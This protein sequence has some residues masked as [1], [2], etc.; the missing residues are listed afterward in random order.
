MLVARDGHRRVA[1]AQAAAVITTI[2]EVH[3]KFANL[4]DARRTLD[5]DME[6]IA[7]DRARLGYILSCIPR[8]L[9]NFGD[10]GG[11]AP[12]PDYFNRHATLHQVCDVQYTPVNALVSLMLMTALLR[13]LDEYDRKGLWEALFTEGENRQISAPGGN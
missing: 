5:L 9:T 7:F 4:G 2:V 6:E 1:Q 11:G 13:E 3:L 12:L 10:R 8:S